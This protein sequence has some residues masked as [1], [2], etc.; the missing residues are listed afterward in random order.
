MPEYRPV[1]IVTGASSGVGAACARQLAE[2]GWNVLV[3]YL[4]NDGGAQE[5]AVVCEAAGADVALVK[6]DVSQDATCRSIAGAAESRWGRVDALVNN[7]GTTKFCPPD[8][9][10]GLSAEDFARIYAVNVIGPYQMTRAVAPLLRGDGGGSVVNVASMAGITGVGSSTAYAASKGAL[11][12][13]TRSLA[14]VLG[15][16]IRVNAVCPGFIQGNWLRR[17]LGEERYENVKRARETGA[18]LGMTMTADL[19]ADG[20]LYFIARAEG[21]TGETLMMDGGHHLGS[22]PLSAR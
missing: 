21:V 20:V 15:P 16:R 13:M 1:A 12:T 4:S 17:A 5:T 7:A 18:P 22:S 10:E 11:I 3:N 2:L 14:R 9:L 8:D 19:V 6:G